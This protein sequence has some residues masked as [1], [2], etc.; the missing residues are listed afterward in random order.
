M[1]FQIILL[2][3]LVIG[4]F[5]LSVLSIFWGTKNLAQG[6]WGL[7]YDFEFFM[8]YWLVRALNLDKSKIVKLIKVMLGAA[9]IVVIFGILQAWL[10]PANFLERFGYSYA[11]GWSPD[12]TLMSNQVIGSFTEGTV[13]HRIISTLAGPNQLGSYLVIIIVLVT[14]MAFFLKN[15]RLKILLGL[16]ALVSLIPLYYTYSRSAW[17]AILVSLLVLAVFW[18]GRKV[19]WFFAILLGFLL[20]LWSLGRMGAL[21]SWF[22]VVL[23]R[24]STFGHWEG[25]TK[26]WQA[27]KLHPFGLGVGRA[28]PVTVRFPEN[29]ILVNESWHW[30]ILTEVGWLGFGLWIWI[31]FEIY[32]NLLKIYRQVAEDQFLKSILVG[33]IAA[34]SGLLVYGF[35]LH[36]WTDISTTLT[37][38]VLIGI[39]FGLMSQEKF[40]EVK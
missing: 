39:S 9:S 5:V 36:T 30:Q 3:K 26:T 18:L 38:W 1:P 29:G 28:G 19:F 31:L 21:G 6:I 11:Y 35:F 24:D 34:F 8:I 2:D 15:F 7:R 22:E 12:V 10:L 37:M 23:T 25:L 16:F 40:K 32:R 13:K 20:F 17:L 27:I 14:S 33:T 4:L